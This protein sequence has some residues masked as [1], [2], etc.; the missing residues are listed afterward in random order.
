M[1]ARNP[2]RLISAGAGLARRLCTAAAATEPEEVAVQAASRS[3]RQ[4]RLYH[5]LSAL[6]AT[7]G[8]VADT[9]NEHIKEGKLIAK[10]ELS[11]CIKQL[12]KYRQFQHALEV[13]SICIFSNLVAEETWAN[14]IIDKF[15][16]FLFLLFSF[17]FSVIKLLTQK[18][19][20]SKVFLS[21][22]SLFSSETKQRVIGFGTSCLHV[23]QYFVND[24]RFGLKYV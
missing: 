7:G 4:P 2:N 3:V 10:H 11:S 8:S 24:D 23:S 20:I 15:W 5:R 12:R 13:V 9:L 16:I 6:G 1:M 17:P 19:Q 22:S 18:W 21:F 14:E